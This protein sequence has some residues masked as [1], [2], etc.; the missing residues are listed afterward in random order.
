M[1]AQVRAPQWKPFAKMVDGREETLLFP[2]GRGIQREGALPFPT[3]CLRL[4]SS[5]PPGMP[6]PKLCTLTPRLLVTAWLNGTSFVKPS[7]ISQLG[8]AFSSF[9]SCCILPEL[10]KKRLRLLFFCVLGVFVQEDWFADYWDGID[11]I[12]FTSKFSIALSTGLHCCEW[13]ESVET[14]NS[15]PPR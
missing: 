5:L 13:E 9:N 1:V 8:V 4:R 7:Q 12:L 6:S 11:S 15:S 10:L 14:G 3:L 2:D